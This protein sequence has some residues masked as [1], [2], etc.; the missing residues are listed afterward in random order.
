MTRL[1]EPEK[2]HEEKRPNKHNKKGLSRPKKKI[3]QNI[4]KNCEENCEIA[5]L[6][7]RNRGQELENLAFP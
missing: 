6:G 4:A 1:L 3:L 2:V 5:V 7:R